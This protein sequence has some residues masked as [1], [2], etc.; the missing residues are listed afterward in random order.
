MEPG[1][2]GRGDDPVDMPPGCGPCHYDAPPAATGPATRP[3]RKSG[4]F[5]PYRVLQVLAVLVGGGVAGLLIALR[6]PQAVAVLGT[7]CAIIGAGLAVL[8]IMM[9]RDGNAGSGRDQT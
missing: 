2:A 1:A 8:D 3:S 6:W 9:R 4:V 5:I 7:I